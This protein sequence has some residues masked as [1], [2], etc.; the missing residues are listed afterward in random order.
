[1]ILLVGLLWIRMYMY[2]EKTVSISA[3]PP[4]GSGASL[5]VVVMLCMNSVRLYTEH[6]Y[7]MVTESKSKSQPRPKSKKQPRSRSK[8][9]PR[10]RS[11][12]QPLHRQQPSKNEQS[13]PVFKYSEYCVSLLY[14]CFVQCVVHGVTFICVPLGWYKVTVVAFNMTVTLYHLL[15]GAHLRNPYVELCGL[16]QKGY[17]DPHITVCICG[18]VLLVAFVLIRCIDFVLQEYEVS[19]DTRDCFDD[20]DYQIALPVKDCQVDCMQLARRE[21]SANGYV[22][23]LYVLLLKVMALMDPWQTRHIEVAKKVIQ[24][25][26]LRASSTQSPKP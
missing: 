11:K 6:V 16:L 20:C 4:P 8:S 14:Y 25:R 9:Q 5:V 3:P 15:N 21:A 13:S 7:A 22:W 23:W 19:A 1:M 12:S 10:S 18:V 26:W 24:P 2:Y 17:H